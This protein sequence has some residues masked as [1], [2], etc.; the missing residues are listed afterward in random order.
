[1]S[2]RSSDLC[3]GGSAASDGGQEGPLQVRKTITSI[4][5]RVMPAITS[6]HSSGSANGS[7]P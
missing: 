6:A 2:R 1:M 3:A 5:G 4:P 7:S